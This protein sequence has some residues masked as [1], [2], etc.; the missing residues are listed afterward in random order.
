VAEAA[1][2]SV[3]LRFRS[4]AP[5]GAGLELA[6]V[7]GREAMSKPFA[8][9]LLL[10]R[11]EGPLSPEE[12]DALFR[13]PCAVALDAG[14]GS[15]VRGVLE[16]IR[17]LDASRDVPTP[18]VAR[19]VPT[20][21]LLT[22]SRTN[23]I[24]QDLTTPEIAAS[25]LASYG[26]SPEKDFRVTASDACPRR[27]YVVQYQESDW[28]F[29]QRWLE[30]DGLASWF[31][32][33][34]FAGGAAAERF[35]VA[36]AGAGSPP[37]HGADSISYRER[38]NL[39]TGGDASVW[40]W[41]LERRRVPARVVVFDYNYRTPHLRLAAKATAD[42]VTG[43]GTVMDYGAH[44]KNLDEGA[45]IAALRA[46]AIACRRE[47]YTGWTDC[48]RFRVGHTF[49][50]ADHFED[51]HRRT[52]LIT[53]LDYTVGEGVP[54][55]DEP[56]ASVGA[57]R[58]AAR[59]T[60]IPAGTPY[61]PEIATPWPSIH[62]VMN[63]HVDADGP[64]HY[65]EID[66][67]GRYKVRLPFDSGDKQ[68]ASVSRWIRMAQPYSGPGY[69]SHHPLHKG[70]EVLV[71]HVDGDPDRPVIVGAAPNP[72]TVSPSTG[73]NATQSVTQTATGIRIEME[74]QAGGPVTLP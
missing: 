59:F 45:R 56:P 4:G 58:Y 67:L 39:S 72:A 66:K 57:H 28:D 5:V 8:L 10:G 73:V 38:N 18:Y 40:G 55:D 24:F 51:A 35:V 9:D 42:A 71:T 49:T 52:Y 19:M 29:L 60:A 65:A 23:R 63:G 6:G 7:R 64:G 16:S 27:E 12:L 3:H 41:E 70:A 14:S 21:W 62:G 33:G 22:L 46:Q 48:A 13:A 44:F 50:L 26:L 74:D 17:Q 37:I 43:F 20:A 36:D 68:G 25:V 15:V 11:K 53:A 32:H 2:E 34:N 47:V 1:L 61:R 31:E 69:G 54:R 30:H